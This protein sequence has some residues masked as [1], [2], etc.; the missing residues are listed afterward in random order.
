MVSRASYRE[1]ED[2][3]M[4]AILVTEHSLL[5]SET[6]VVGLTAGN[7]KVDISDNGRITVWKETEP[8]LFEIAFEGQIP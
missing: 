6:K 4:K 2:D 1:S 3:Y 7:W 5:K 8:H